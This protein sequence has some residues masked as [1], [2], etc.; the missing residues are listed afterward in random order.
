LNSAQLLTFARVARTT[1]FS[2]FA[3]STF[4]NAADISVVGVFPGKAVLIVDGAQPKTFAVGSTIGTSKLI[5]VDN[6][7]AVFETNGKRENLLVGQHSQ[8]IKRSN[9]KTV[10]QSDL[11]GHVITDV[12]V[13]GSPIKMLLDT[14]ATSI[15]IPAAE[16]RRLKLNYK[17]GTI[18]PINTANGRSQGYMLK[19]DTVRVG[20][21]QLDG[22]EAVIV[23]N[24][25]NVGLLGMSFLKRTDMH[26]EGR[27]V[28]LIK[29]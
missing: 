12:Y 19:L 20:D 4:A 5:A 6:N 23:E 8:P 15:A 24:G 7:G 25:L 13:N 16:A 27:E 1:L 2:L 10:L 28:T 18:V 17:T 14:G 3:M 22:V 26:R 29:H 21:L 11:N 9:S